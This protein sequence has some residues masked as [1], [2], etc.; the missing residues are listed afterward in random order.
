[1]LPTTAPKRV[2]IWRNPRALASLIVFV[3][4]T[5]V[6]FRSGAKAETERNGSASGLK[7]PQNRKLE[8]SHLVL[9]DKIQQLS[10][11]VV[12]RFAMRIPGLLCG[13]HVV[14]SNAYTDHFCPSSWTCVGRDQDKSAV[15]TMLQHIALHQDVNVIAPLIW[16]KQQDR[17][18]FTVA[19]IW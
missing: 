13:V 14:A 9:M 8:S 6:G 12:A 19:S 18:L 5:P 7:Q 4:S 15:R 11:K 17:K 3:T 1:M 10:F 16:K 2:K